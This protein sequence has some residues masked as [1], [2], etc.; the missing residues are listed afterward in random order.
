MGRPKL[1]EEQRAASKARQYEQKKKYIKKWQQKNKDHVN[2]YQREWRK[3]N[4]E[5]YKAAMLRHY[6]KLLNQT[7]TEVQDG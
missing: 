3:K 1:T 2:E 7:I 6:Q 5:K 4:P